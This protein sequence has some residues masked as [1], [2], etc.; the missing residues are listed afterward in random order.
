MMAKSKREVTC[1][2][3]QKGIYLA[4]AGAHEAAVDIS[5]QIRA[6]FGM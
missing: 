5:N 1:L 6:N 4:R 3:A 2:T